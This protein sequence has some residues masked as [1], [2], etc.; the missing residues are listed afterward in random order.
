MT[1]M[2][3]KEIP[4]RE[5]RLAQLQKQLQ[6]QQQVQKQ[7]PKQPGQ[8]P[9]EQKPQPEQGPDR[10][11]KRQRYNWKAIVTAAI[12]IVIVWQL[13]HVFMNSHKSSTGAPT[14][15]TAPSSKPSPTPT[16]TIGGHRVAAGA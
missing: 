1:E 10:R 14:K 3:P 9:L 6:L 11:R 8:K 16:V 13:A 4:P 12:A 2:P 15:P 5:D 7:V